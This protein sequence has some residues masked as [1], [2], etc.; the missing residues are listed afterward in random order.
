MDIGL[1]QNDMDHYL[2]KI[3]EK[4][5]T[6]GLRAVTDEALQIGVRHDR[7]G[8]TDRGKT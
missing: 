1:S 2:S 4:C 3:K 8:T 6:I 7:R 5:T